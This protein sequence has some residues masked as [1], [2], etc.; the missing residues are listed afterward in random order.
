VLGCTGAYSR[1]GL[2]LDLGLS[3][4]VLLDRA[5]HDRLRAD[6]D[7]QRLALGLSGEPEWLVTDRPAFADG[8]CAAC[9]LPPV[10]VFLDGN[11]GEGGIYHGA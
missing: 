11:S 9:D 7:R 10:L 8:R 4:V 3:P 6:A 2:Y 5:A 1:P